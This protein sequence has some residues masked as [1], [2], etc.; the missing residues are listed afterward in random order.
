MTMNP[1]ELATFFGVDEGL[2]NRIKQ[3]A[4]NARSFSHWLEQIKTKRY[5]QTRLQRMFVHI[6]T[7]TTKEAMQHYTESDNVPYLRLLGMS[8]V[9][10]QY[11]NQQK[12]QLTI[13]MITNVKRDL[14]ADITMDERATDA[15][16]AVLNANNRIK[17]RKQDFIGPLFK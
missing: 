7:N 8:K 6:L 17:L 4:R 9:G 14:S 16:Y 1:K 5:T 12:K 10:R 13:P 15:Y 2:E 3:T 11:L